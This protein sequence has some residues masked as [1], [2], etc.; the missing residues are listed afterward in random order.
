MVV[1]VCVI[2][3]GPCGMLTLCAYK[4]LQSKGVDVEVTCY[5]KQDTPGGLW[6]FTWMTGI[7]QYG[8]PLHNSQYRDLFSNGPKEA[9][10]FPDYTFMD[11]FKKQLPSYPPRAVLLDYLQ[12]Y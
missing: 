12:G 8:E 1:R 7:D 2:G 4:K 3:A 6:N 11:H 9:V 5:E 10:E